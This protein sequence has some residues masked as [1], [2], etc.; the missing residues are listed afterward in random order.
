[1]YTSHSMPIDRSRFVIALIGKLSWSSLAASGRFQILNNRIFHAFQSMESRNQ[2]S[3][4]AIFGTCRAQSILAWNLFSRS[5]RIFRQF[6][7]KLGL[8]DYIRGI[9]I[10]FSVCHFHLC[11]ETS[12][13]MNMDNIYIRMILIFITENHP[14]SLALPQ[15]NMEFQ[16]SFWRWLMAS[17]SFTT[18]I[19]AI[20][21]RWKSV[22][23]LLASF[24]ERF[25][26]IISVVAD[27]ITWNWISFLQALRLSQLAL[28][29]TAPGKLVNLLSNDVQRFN[30][31]S[32]LHP[33]WFAPV[34]TVVA[35]FILWN[36]IRWAGLIGVA[37]ILAFIPIQSNISRFSYTH[38]CQ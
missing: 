22:W 1:M 24:T 12:L 25:F 31:L 34:T 20:I 37:I 11:I 14:N 35:T 17:A 32:T 13:F 7:Y 29:E 16:F 21:M 26:S 18:F 33:L 27:L 36:E 30:T 5:S 9:S 19:T 3:S 23:H 6:R 2:K 28:S 38:W 15:S 10:I 4:T 8:G